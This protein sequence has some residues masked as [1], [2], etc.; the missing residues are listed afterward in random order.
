[1]TRIAAFTLIASVLLTACGGS[2]AADQ[3]DARK[4]VAALTGDDKRAA[5]NNPHCKMFTQAEVAKFIGE[6]VSAG[7][8]AAMGSGCQWL[9]TVGRGNVMVQIVPSNYH[10]RP[11]L[12]DGFKEVAGIGARGFVVPESGGWGAGAIEGKDAIRVS[13]V[14]A[15]ASEASA[16]AL[17]K[18]AIG[19]RAR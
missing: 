4:A 19:R 2:Q 11:S 7:R 6:P 5:A 16:L 3:S 10:E 1:M 15:S 8:T 9:A 12:A 13:V 17:L 18:E 14:G